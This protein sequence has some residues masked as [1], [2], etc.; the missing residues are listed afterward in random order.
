MG[1]LL[2]FYT[3]R[4]VWYNTYSIGILEQRKSGM[5]KVYSA[6]STGQGSPA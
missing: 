6:A 5:A 3:N 1:G 2:F 4:G